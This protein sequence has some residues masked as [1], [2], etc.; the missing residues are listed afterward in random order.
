MGDLVDELVQRA[1]D[2]DF[3][4]ITMLQGAP[5]RWEPAQPR[6]SAV[7][8]CALWLGSAGAVPAAYRLRGVGFVCGRECFRYRYG[9]L[10]VFAG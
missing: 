3:A 6:V 10:L 5:S 9:P 1:P 8:Y 2:P 7:M 4:P